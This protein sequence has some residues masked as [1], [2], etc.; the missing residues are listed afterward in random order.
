MIFAENPLNSVLGL[1]I[2]KETFYEQKTSFLT[3]VIYIY[4]Y[5]YIRILSTYNINTL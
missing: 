4:I 1:H 3:D 2:Y 5:I